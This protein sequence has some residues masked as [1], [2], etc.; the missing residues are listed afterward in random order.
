MSRFK[1]TSVCVGKKVMKSKIA[2]F[3]L[4]LLGL[5]QP[6]QA[7]TLIGWDIPTSA[8]VPVPTGTTVLAGMSVATG[9]T[10]GNFTMGTG[11]TSSVQSS[12]WRATS[13]NQYNTLG[14]TEPAAL[15]A[16]NTAGDYWAFQFGA[17]SGYS[18]TVNGIGSG[19]WT[20]SNAGP[21]RMSMIYS[22]S[23]DF[24][25]YSTIATAT[26]VS[27][28]SVNF[29]SSFTTELGNAPIT[30][31]EGS[32]GYFRLVGYWGTST[33]GNGGLIGN[34]TA[35]DF[36]ILGDIT[37]LGLL[38]WTGGSGIWENGVA[39]NWQNPTGASTAWAAGKDAAIGN[40]GTLAVDAGGVTAGV[41]M[42]SGATEATLTGGALSAGSL[43]MTAGSTLNL[44]NANSAVSGAIDLTDATLSGG[45]LAVGSAAV[46]VSTGTKTI[47]TSLS[48]A[49]ATLTKSGA[50]ELI[51]SGDNT[52]G[53]QTAVA[54]GTLTTGKANILSDTATLKLDNLATFKLGG[55][56]TVGNINATFGSTNN[57]QG[58]T[59]TSGGNNLSATNGALT[60]GSGRLIKNGTGEMYLNQ[61]SN[62]YTGG[63][64][65]NEG[66]VRFS[67]SGDQA[68][69]ILTNSVFG[70]G[71]LALNGGTIGSSATSSPRN[72]YNSVTLNNTVQVGNSAAFAALTT[73]AANGTASL[74]FSTNT[75]G[76][77]TLLG[78]T[79]LNTVGQ[80]LWEQNISGSEYR[81]TKGGT[82]A[83]AISNNYLQLRG[84]NNIA[85]VTVN[86]GILGY[87]NRN[88]LGTGTL[89]L[90]DGVMVGQDGNINNTTTADTV[91]D[92]TVA[93]SISV[94]GS[95][96]F[97]LGGATA[98]YFSGNVNLNGAN[99]TLTVAND[100]T[101]T[102]SITNGGLVVQRMDTDL[103]S[104]KSLALYGANTYDGGT[105]V[106][107]VADRANNVTLGL[108][109]NSALGTGSLTFSGGGTNTIRG[110]KSSAST[111]TSRTI[112]NDIAINSG[113]TL[114]VDAKNS[115]DMV[116]NGV[117]SGGGAL[118]KTNATTLTLGG[119]NTY[120][121]GTT[122]NGGT[123]AYGVADALSSGAVTV[124]GSGAVL[125]IAT[126]SDTVGAVTLTTGS[127]T[128][129][130]GVLTGT[131]FAM[132]GTGS[133]SAI[134]GGSG[135]TLTKTGAGTTTTLSGA[136]TYTGGTL[137][138]AGTLIGTTASLQGTITNN[139]A[140]IFDQSSTGSYNGVMS[141]T[142]SLSKT[143]SGTVT[144]GGANTY[145]G[146]TTVNGGTLMVN[147]SV[148][149][150]TV[151]IS[152]SLG[153]SGT[154]GALT[155]QNGAFLTPGNSPGTL[156]AT[157]AIILGGS[158][159]NW[160][161]SALAETAGTTNWDLFS[162]TKLLDM[163]DVTSS[164]R[165]NLVITPDS[166]FTGWTDT[167]EYSYVFAQAESVSGFSDVD[168]TD[169][170]S[171]FNITTANIASLPN[172][173][174]NV[175]GDF[176]VVVRS[177]GDLTT[178][179]LMAIP[180]PSTGSLLG[181]GLAGLVVTRLLRR[182]QS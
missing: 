69:G 57:L 61:K 20:I 67:S 181:F 145:T 106:V 88:A 83:L 18:V 175:N 149:A 9:V 108:G 28:G 107:G 139:S 147:G 86:S 114:N 125:D 1:L 43:A 12:S 8:T 105:T 82:G 158:T 112:A 119:A 77:T 160:Q 38:S 92:R 111:D 165:W 171:L 179:K 95:A 140:V 148:G 121:G 78:N 93:N 71:T 33:G 99:R 35:P 3:T 22:T 126:F 155:L 46:T 56:E 132:N 115:L 37:S 109:N 153:G 58:F 17:S 124:N 21:T 72:I 6:A 85:G 137:V 10:A 157:S 54:A 64:T 96:T 13:Y 127:I 104:S 47:S 81:L 166:G 101:F 94:L 80:T 49:T 66:E 182:K 159:Y 52:Y 50:G 79:T 62:N 100:T 138:S 34:L 84:S 103:T 36:S 142:G 167:N 129:T 29:V 7:I 151:N 173:F 44:N 68:A 174:Y 180:E 76:S 128:G 176:K 150:V 23:A 51:L 161:I 60:T 169:I 30:I 73:N 59:L 74:T 26:A 122:V 135:A 152:G 70:L 172:P 130:T 116:L 31:G 162:V 15:A 5:Y 45:N 146:G 55:D 48:G 98:S 25:S 91:A 154:V 113:V 75:S 143:N 178:L 87:K 164:N 134:L 2:I 16:A 110:E 156:T 27:G 11:L 141:G 24:A 163:S 136:N 41:V 65:L 42:V 177:A 32:T 120:A 118:I 63:F 144:L 53:G 117:I 131:S 89:I 170:T 133:A 123:L 102:G 40:G 19:T 90:A 4:S 168:G 39:A 97:G 14:I